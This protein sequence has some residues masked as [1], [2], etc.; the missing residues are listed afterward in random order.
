MAIR[1]RGPA[2]ALALGCLIALACAV[3]PAA[4]ADP[5]PGE[6]PV[7]VHSMLY[8]DT[9]AGFM[10]TMFAQAAA[11]HASDIRLDVAPALI[12]PTATG[13]P[14]F[15][16]L[17]MVMSLARE[18]RLRVLADLITVPSWMSSC[19]GPDP[20]L[21]ARCPPDDRAAYGAM[22]ARIVRHADPVITDW[23]VWNEPDR[24]EFFG[25]TPTDYAWMLRT[26]SDAIKGVDASDRV[27][28]GGLT[29]T[30][31][32]R[33]LDQVFATPQADAGHAFDIADIHERGGLDTLAGDVSAWRSHLAAAGFTGPLWVTEHGYPADPSSQWDPAYRSGADAQAAYLQASIPT[34]IDA[35]AAR[36]FV[37]ERDNLGGADASEGL[38]GGDV[39]DPPVADPQVVPRPAFAAVARLDDCYRQTGRDC[40]SAG[41]VADPATLALP[42]V[43]LGYGSDATLTVSDP[44][45]GP[46][47]L[48]PPVLTAAPASG[49][50]V[51]G[52]GCPEILEPDQ[53][54]TIEIHYAPAAAGTTFARLAV[55]SDQGTLSVPVSAVA[56]SAS[57]LTS[58]EL[59]APRFR[60][61][62]D[63]DGVGKPQTLLMQIVNPLPA[64]V[65]TAGVTLSGPDAARFTVVANACRGVVLDPGQSC[66]LSVIA[67][68]AHPGTSQATLSLGGQGQ[69]LVVPLAVTAYPTP[70]ITFLGPARGGAACARAGLL[71]LIDRPAAVGWR[72]TR[73]LGRPDPRCAPDRMPGRRRPTGRSAIAISQ[74]SGRGR[75]LRPARVDGR[76]GYATVLRVGASLAP[77][78]YRV[79]ASAADAHGGGA[80]RTVMITVAP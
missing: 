9:P 35:G 6:S 75:A 47:V 45:P 21:A 26:A 7:G 12:F 2:A 69:P 25:G 67:V 74:A 11:L 23:E 71:V 59:A 19:P 15:S 63:G 56:A 8:L 34:L 72:A 79:A 52:N 37:T 76:H 31:G 32:M 17:D 36:V 40:P 64:A 33:W 70:R 13:T 30:A 5:G 60:M 65:R 24:G 53:T 54:C 57:A 4:A 10:R 61:A 27:L 39:A 3:T 62:A 18:Y 58:P 48:S 66:G 42:A 20:E 49:L 16:G 73:V 80:G 41:P 51:S 44:G 46:L 68:P 50:S 29:N 43:A 22:I 14:D 55:V 78:V 77:G 1:R 38:L 28:L